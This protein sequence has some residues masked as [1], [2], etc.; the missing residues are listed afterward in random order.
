M[1]G[2]YLMREA[3][4]ISLMAASFQYPNGYPELLRVDQV[5]FL[6][7]VP[8]GSIMDLKSRVTLI[9]ELPGIG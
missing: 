6:A 9:K 5:L 8:A 4:D 2:G 3:F 1:F 7:P